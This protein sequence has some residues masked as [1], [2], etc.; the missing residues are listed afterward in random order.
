M[1]A[2]VSA[3]NGPQGVEYD[4]PRIEEIW[5]VDSELWQDERNLYVH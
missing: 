5:P 4:S 2:R 3:T 1:I